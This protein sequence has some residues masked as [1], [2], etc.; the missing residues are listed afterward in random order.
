MK[1]CKS[2]LLSGILTFGMAGL[3]A[4]EE[5][6]ISETIQ[7]EVKEKLEIQKAAPTIDLSIQ[8]IVESGTARTDDVLQQ[9]Q[10]IPSDQDFAHY[11]YLDSK[12]IIRPWMP[13]IPEPPLVKF[14]PGLS[15]VATKRWSFKVSN[16]TG[17]VVKVIKGKGVPPQK[18]EWD[19][20]NERGEYIGVG[21]LYSYQ[22]I[23]YDE[24]GNAHTFPGEPFELDA[25]Q[26]K[27]K[28]NLY[29]EFSNERLF[30]DEAAIIRPSM[31]NIWER[32]IDVVRQYSNKPLRVEMYAPSATSPLAEE[33]R[34]VIVSAISDGT[35]IPAVDIRHKV[36]KMSDRGNIVR[37]VMKL[38]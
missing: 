7:Y 22:F 30:V 25:L 31:K 8:E 35:N 11:A 15:K 24:H 16:E 6:G 27:Q 2:I 4:E 29:V 34:Q 28:R 20:V 26:Y 21:T 23:T 36:E 37:L 38:K 9:A 17:D 5:E 1:K 33:R 12:Q 10:P 13:L 19:G 14:Y 18:F 3:Y 32:A